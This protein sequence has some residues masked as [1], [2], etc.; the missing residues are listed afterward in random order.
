MQPDIKKEKE[1]IETHII[2]LMQLVDEQL[3]KY[4]ELFNKVLEEKCPSQ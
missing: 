3:F 4:R 2:T 1:L